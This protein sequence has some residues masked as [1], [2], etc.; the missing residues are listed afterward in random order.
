[1]AEVAQAAVGPVLQSAVVP[2][3][4]TPMNMGPLR[5]EN[6]EG[7][8]SSGKMVSLADLHVNTNTPGTGPGHPEIHVSIFIDF[9]YFLQ[10]S[11]AASSRSSYFLI[12]LRELILLTLWS[13]T[14]LET[15]CFVQRFRQT[16]FTLLQ[17]QLSRS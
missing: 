6:T 8:P 7:P 15:A 12:S 1:M 10:K 13:S 2:V 14:C 9:S 5:L 16:K 4:T 3:A 11:H 17:L